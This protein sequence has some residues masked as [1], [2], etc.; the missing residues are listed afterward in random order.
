MKNENTMKKYT[1]L[2][3][4]AMICFTAISAQKND[5]VPPAGSSAIGI[6][7]NPVSGIRANS[8]FQAGDFIGNAIVAQAAS[9]YQM[10]IL[11]DP[12][13]S[14]RYK[15]K[16]NSTTAFRASLGFSGAKFNYKEFILDD[17]T[18]KVDPLSTDQVEDIIHFGMIG[19]GMNVG[20]EFSGGTG[21]LRFTGGFGVVYSFGGG[22]MRFTY[23]NTMTEDNPA[24]TVMPLIDSLRGK[25]YF[26]D[27]NLANARP[28][29]RYNVGI[30][31]AFGLSLDLGIEWFFAKNL[32]LGASVNLTPLI[33]AIQ[34]ETYT[35]F[36]GYSITDKSVMNFAKKIS[37]GSNYLLYG[38][39]NIGLL[40][41]INYYF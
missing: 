19:G 17:I 14:F 33:F 21:N 37:S 2:L 39:E 40:I 38:T 24:P 7:V 6:V 30:E 28:L 25:G 29:E 13:I 15:Y 36:E 3:A 8:I 16:I 27:I 41:S 22:S 20:L 32:S 34:P 10:F 18:H 35:N 11:A 12:M 26:Y 4:F 31:H 9:P 23:G 5:H 1:L